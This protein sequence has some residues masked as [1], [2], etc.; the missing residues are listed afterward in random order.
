MM[1]MK[2]AVLTEQRVSDDVMESMVSTE[3]E[4][5]L[6]VILYRMVVVVVVAAANYLFHYDVSP[7]MMMAVV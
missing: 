7:M 3:I 5:M 6:M 1:A 4:H 2:V